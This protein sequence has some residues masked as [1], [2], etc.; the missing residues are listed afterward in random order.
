MAPRVVKFTVPCLFSS[1]LSFLCPSLFPPELA[2][3]K[4]QV[5]RRVCTGLPATPNLAGPVSP[6]PCPCVFLSLPLSPSATWSSGRGLVNRTRMF[7]YVLVPI[8]ST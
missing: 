5:D 3:K 6:H 4:L 8:Y 2:A 1:F 7:M